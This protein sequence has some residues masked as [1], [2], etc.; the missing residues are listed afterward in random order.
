[1]CFCFVFKEFSFKY[2]FVCFYV[3][4]LSTVVR[5]FKIFSLMC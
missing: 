4:Y 3:F 1:M 5:K 2:S